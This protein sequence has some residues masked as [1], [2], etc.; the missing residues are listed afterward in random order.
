MVS[1]KSVCFFLRSSESSH[2]PNA[3]K[4][5]NSF[6]IAFKDLQILQCFY[7]VGVITCT[8]KTVLA[9]FN[10][11]RYKYFSKNV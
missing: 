3:L 5:C 7:S 2:K 4:R 6:L 10:I 8:T 9:M 1:E 11:G